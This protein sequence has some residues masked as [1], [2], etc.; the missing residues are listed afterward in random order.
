MGFSLLGLAEKWE[1]VLG[2]DREEE[3]ESSCFKFMAMAMVAGD[4][5]N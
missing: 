2:R 1:S 5:L 3:A 4:K